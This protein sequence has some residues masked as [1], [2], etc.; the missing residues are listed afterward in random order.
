MS[1]LLN[2]L[3]SP[4]LV[5]NF[6]KVFGI[7]S[8]FDHNHHDHA[9]HADLSSYRADVKSNGS[10]SS[11]TAA[12]GRQRAA[13]KEKEPQTSLSNG[14]NG[15]S[16]NGSNGSASHHQESSN[17]TDGGEAGGKKKSHTRTLSNVKTDHSHI[18]ANTTIHSKFFWIFFHL[19]AA[20]GNEIFYCLFFPFWFWNVDGAIARKV[21][22]LWGVFMYIGQAT[23]DFLCMP[24]PASPPVVKLESRYVAEYGFPSTHAMVS[25]GLPISLVVLSY[26]RYNISL[27]ISLGVAGLFCCWVC[28]SRLY[29]G[30]HSLLDVIAGVLYSGLVLLMVMPFLEPIDNFILTH[31]L[32]PYTVLIVGFLL[33]KFYPSLKQWSTARGDTTIIIGTVVGFSIGSY[34]NYHLGFLNKPDDP[35]L[36]NIQFPNALGYLLGVV[37]TILGLLTLLMTRQVFKKYLLKFLCQL[38]GLDPADPACKQNIKIEL[39]YNYLTYFAVGLNISF[40]SPLLFRILYIA[41]DYSFTEL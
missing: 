29:L 23:K 1:E 10:S 16:R 18:V 37:R 20:M 34:L 6:Q 24:R 36:Y 32:S 7:E 35:P 12:N 25:A 5:A 2:Y 26:Y 22:F 27:P 31:S 13:K 15:H 8:H 28:C 4:D 41:R 21:G 33:C 11:L 30:M 19:G 39:P 14:H 17:G 3:N 38:N 9:I 40:A